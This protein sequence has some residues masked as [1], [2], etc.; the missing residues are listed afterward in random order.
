MQTARLA[1]LAASALLAMALALPA[2]ACTKPRGAGGLAAD[3]IDAANSYRAKSGLSRMSPDAD[4]AAVAQRQACDMAR[5]GKISHKGADGAS[6]RT[7]MKREGLSSGSENV[8]SG[9]NTGGSVV[10]A[11]MGSD[12]HRQNLMARGNRKA[13]VG[14]AVD[15]SGKV[16]WAMVMTN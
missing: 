16:Y 4:A 15:R 12:G 1:T 6:F 13:G 8:A 3:A 7:R 10:T 2:A 5:T 11:W 14:V 9:L